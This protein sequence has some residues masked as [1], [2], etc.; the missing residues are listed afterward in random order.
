MGFTGGDKMDN[1]QERFDILLNLYADVIH[2]RNGHD[3][4]SNRNILDGKDCEECK[5]F[6][7]WEIDGELKRR[8]EEREKPNKEE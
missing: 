3:V 5:E 1:L 4:A 7:N 8:K 6:I 2:S